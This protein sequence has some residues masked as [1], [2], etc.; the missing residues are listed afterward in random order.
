M[1]DATKA[2]LD[3]ISG[4]LAPLPDYLG[5]T[6]GLIE[7]F[8]RV[9]A[10][11][12]AG[13]FAAANPDITQLADDIVKIIE[14]LERV[15]AGGGA[16]EDLAPL[17]T[18]VAKA[19][20]DLR[21][22]PSKLPLLTL[23][24]DVFTDLF[25][26]LLVDHLSW[27]H[28]V[29]LQ[30]LILLG[31]LEVSY[32][33]PSGTGVAY[34]R[35]DFHWDAI[36]QFARDP[37]SWAAAT[38]GWGTDHFRSDVLL[39]RLFTLFDA[40]GLWTKLTVVPPAIATKFYPGAGTS[41][42]G[43]ELPFYH[44]EPAS[45]VELEAGLLAMPVGGKSAP[46]ETDVGIGVMPYAQGVVDATVPVTPS[47]DL[48]LQGSA[49]MAGG[50]VIALRPQS[51]LETSAGNLNNVATQLG[52]FKIELLAKP[53]AGASSILIFG[54]PTTTR[55]EVA[56][57]L[58]AVGGKDTDFYVALGV[59]GLKLTIDA[60]S[61]GL[62][63]KLIPKGTNVTVG[64]VLVGW[65]P[66]RG[67]YFD[68][69]AELRLVLP[70]ELALG[71]ARLHQIEARVE[72]EPNLRTALLVSADLTIGPLFLA[73]DGLGVIA[74]FVPSKQG[75]LGG[76]DVTLGLATPSGYAAALNGPITGG[77]LI[78][79]TDTGYQGALAL[80]FSSFALSAFAIL[81][82]KMPE[83][84]SGYSFLA[85][86]FGEFEVQLGAGFKLTG[87]GGLVGIHR[88]S[89]IEALR[90][91][92]R[93]GHLDG[94]LFPPAP[95]QDASRILHDMA[96]IF[97]PKEG[98]YLF[99]PMA[100]IAY[101]TPTLVEG[102]VGVIIELGGSVR[103]LIL[104]E[105]RAALPTKES[106]VLVLNIDFVGVIDFDARTLAIDATLANSRLLSWPI[107]GDIALRAS[108]GDHSDFAFSIGGFHPQFAAPA[109]FPTLKR[110]SINFGSNN[111]KLTLTAYFALTLNT[112]QAGA[113]LDL[114][115]DGPDTWVG[116]FDVDGHAWFDAIVRFNPFAFDV[117]L[118]LALSLLRDG[119]VFC[120]IGGDLRLSG[121]N[122]YH[123][124]GKVWAE[125]CHIE[126][127]V[128]VD[129]TFGT[130]VDEPLETADALAAL[131]KAV[132]ERASWESVPVVGLS[133][134]VALA[135]LDPIADADKVVVDPLGGL[136]FAEHAVPLKITIA[137]LGQARLANQFNSFALTAVD[138]AG[139]AIAMSDAYAPFAA[140]QFLDL[141]ES[142]LLRAP[143]TEQYRSGVELVGGTSLDFL[144]SA[145]VPMTYDYE[146]VS[147]VDETRPTVLGTYSV[148]PVAA[149][150]LFKA[151]LADISSP[152]DG[153]YVPRELVTNP[154]RVQDLSFVAVSTKAT[155]KGIAP[156]EV[157]GRPVVGTYAD[158]REAAPSD[159]IF[160]S[161][162]TAP[163]ASR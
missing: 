91:V 142:E 121:P 80:K 138:P 82:T 113:H 23:G 61:D 16:P 59:G 41:L 101:G 2:I 4:V 119:D 89:D 117:A 57:A 156:L 130:S 75:K 15:A 78:A 84:A 146:T 35:Y 29:I 154:V 46:V 49:M 27:Q 127:D 81:T 162:V 65:R 153:G 151:G 56:S 36:S 144:D 128:G 73:A 88:T 60:S 149:A 10:S 92:L 126:V 39:S 70:V 67:I 114:W 107:S 112:A 45:G 32:V 76:F 74:T 104:G 19:F 48:V 30:T 13:A 93:A 47:L 147:L 1:S 40:A 85:T 62:L 133:A 115:V 58:A 5:S 8:E 139:N 71:P 100:R 68:G 102:K 118:G 20:D 132:T 136:R 52:D 135:K 14:Q 122:P 3:E 50:I 160:A 103:I 98:T 145:V 7:L 125:I 53:A 83:G 157:N 42:T 106:A 34:R 109:N 105:V 26:L 51:G 161:Y 137:K 37:K 21:T 163:A 38:Y 55:L 96:T 54:T 140:G 72:F 22:L 18:D 64:N 123:I 6:D 12:N 9:G 17:L 120:G 33:T 158:A 87:L 97:P 116:K 95:I 43:A 159:L 79:R 66:G 11:S 31:A 129:K 152:R 99:G 111:P 28:P 110:V 108:W 90:A 143:A 134:H 124:R 86:I 148:P 155:A 77:G 150:R 25:S 63:G 141:S 24:A 44:V 94:L 131:V 69:G